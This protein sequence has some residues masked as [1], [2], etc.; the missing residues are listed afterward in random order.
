MVFF[1][2]SPA[3]QI[4]GSKLFLMLTNIYI[5]LLLPLLS[6]FVFVVF[7]REFLYRIE[8]RLLRRFRFISCIQHTTY[9][10]IRSYSWIIFFWFVSLNCGAYLK[11][12]IYAAVFL[13]NISKIQQS[14]LQRKRN[15]NFT[16][17]FRSKVVIILSQQQFNVLKP[18]HKS[19]NTIDLCIFY[20]FVCR[21]QTNDSD[22]WK[23][24]R[25]IFSRGL[26]CVL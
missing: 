21:C 20:I 2:L 1:F 23:S 25:A 15:G 26:R 4:V 14:P 19:E 12:V 22:C 18:K 24:T 9:I 3:N 7:S 8:E 16:I 11:W 6:V 10:T 17:Q 13:H 5:R